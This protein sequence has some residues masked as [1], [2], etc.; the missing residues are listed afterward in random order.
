MNGSFMRINNYKRLSQVATQRARELRRDSTNAEKILW[1]ALRNRKL[2]NK[3]FYRQKPIYYDEL[4]K[5]T[6]FI[7]DFYCHEAKLVIEV[8]GGIHN[9]QKEEDMT[10]TEVLNLLGI[11]VIRFKNDEVEKN[12]E[13]VLEKI[14]YV[15]IKKPIS[16][17]EKGLG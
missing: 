5:D 3:K 15:I 7:A 16:S 12:I 10:R 13:Y 14:K 11:N 2:M 17:K 1:D 6:F 8:D 4:V 9:Y